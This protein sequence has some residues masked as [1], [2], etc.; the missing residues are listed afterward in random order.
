[1]TDDYSPTA[2]TQAHRR[3][4][5]VESCVDRLGDPATGATRDDEAVRAVA[6]RSIAG[7]RTE[8]RP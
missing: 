2:A 7:L 1:M 6:R 3:E 4:I 5:V 8:A